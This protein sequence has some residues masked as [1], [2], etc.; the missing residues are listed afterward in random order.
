[1]TPFEKYSS[2]KDFIPYSK[3]GNI[4]YC[5]TGNL[6]N[7]LKA[8]ENI[9][10]YACRIG[11]HYIGVNQPV[12]SCHKCSYEGEM[13]TTQNGFICPNC[14]NNDPEKMHVI[15]RICG[16]L[17]VGTRSGCKDIGFNNGKVH[18]IIERVKHKK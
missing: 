1:M 3:G 7:N 14:G 16:Y 5:E 9:I 2:E 8:L 12:D 13:N 4:S 11:I 6:K 17:S 18:E 10:D 15:R